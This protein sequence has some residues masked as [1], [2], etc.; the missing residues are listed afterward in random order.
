MLGHPPA[1]FITSIICR[2]LQRQIQLTKCIWETQMPPM[3][4]NFKV[5]KVTWT[6]Y[7]YCHKKY[8]SSNIHYL[9]VMTNVNIFIAPQTKFGKVEY[10][11]QSV[12]LS[13]C[14]RLWSKEMGTRIFLKIWTSITHILKMCF[15]DWIIFHHFKCIYLFLDHN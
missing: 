3:M 5:V 12:R 2:C 9:E 15:S 11:I 6:I 4:A 1:V 8:E 14:S 10:W 7:W 13:I